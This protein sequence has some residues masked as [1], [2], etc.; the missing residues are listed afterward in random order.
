MV[1][2]VNKLHQLGLLGY[3]L[4]HSVNGKEFITTGQL[5]KELLDTLT[6]AG[7]RESLVS[8]HKSSYEQAAVFARTCAGPAAASAVD[9]Q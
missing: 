8:K 2:L 1:E 3:D 7:G 5:R 4:L 6:E 9:A